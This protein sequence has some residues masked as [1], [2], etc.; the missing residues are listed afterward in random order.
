MCPCSSTSWLWLHLPPA[1]THL[2]KL[3]AETSPSSEVSAGEGG[4]KKVSNI[5]FFQNVIWTHEQMG[6]SGSSPA[7]GI[8]GACAPSPGSGGVKTHFG[9][10]SRRW[11]PSG[12]LPEASLIAP[13]DPSAWTLAPRYD[14]VGT[15]A[16]TQ[17]QAGGSLLSFADIRPRTSSELGFA[18]ASCEMTGIDRS[19]CD[20]VELLY[21]QNTQSARNWLALTGQEEFSGLGFDREE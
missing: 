2:G 18:D 3:E 13:S 6:T 7:A 21:L 10:S 4:K 14:P 19:T 15:L 12:L 8:W 1:P 16:H 11:L 9:L 20:D 5:F 17:P